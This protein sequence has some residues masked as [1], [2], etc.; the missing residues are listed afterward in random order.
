MSTIS[1]TRAPLSGLK[2]EAIGLYRSILRRIRSHGAEEGKSKASDSPHA[3]ANSQSATSS[4][5]RS[6]L[7]EMDMRKYARAQFDSN[8]SI[9]KFDI[10]RI[11]Y[12]IRQGKKQLDLLNQSGGRVKGLRVITST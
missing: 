2:R 8:R 11:E 6:S 12:C 10:M 1:A 4:G 3:N 5:S 7:Q 9:S